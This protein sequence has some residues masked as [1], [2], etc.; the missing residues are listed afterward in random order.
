MSLSYNVSN[1]IHCVPRYTGFD[2]GEGIIIVGAFY[3]KNARES[4]Y[5]KMSLGSLT[6]VLFPEPNKK[7]KAVVNFVEDLRV[8]QHKAIFDCYRRY[9]AAGGRVL[10]LQSRKQVCKVKFS[11]V[12]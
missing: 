7:L 6:K 2:S 4:S 8:S 11:D 1:V 10:T 12:M 9:N 5:A 3:N